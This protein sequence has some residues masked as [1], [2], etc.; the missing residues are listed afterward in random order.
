MGNGQVYCSANLSEWLAIQGS[1]GEL[2]L[3]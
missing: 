1:G 2:W 3:D